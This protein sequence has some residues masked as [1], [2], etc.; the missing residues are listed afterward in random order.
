MNIPIPDNSS[1][2]L[3]AVAL[4]IETYPQNWDQDTWNTFGSFRGQLAQNTNNME[5][6]CGSTACIAGWAV[7]FTPFD[8]EILNKILNQARRFIDGS[9]DPDVWS[10]AGRY[11]LGLDGDLAYAL[12]YSTWEL[13]ETV[14][15]LRALAEIPEGERDL[16]TAIETLP[17]YLSDLLIDDESWDEDDDIDDDE[18]IEEEA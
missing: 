17:E 9:L 4:A 7:R 3:R 1:E 13:H 15:M 16:S 6:A 5:D 11:A 18:P 8:D 14:A 12:F 10:A 2:R